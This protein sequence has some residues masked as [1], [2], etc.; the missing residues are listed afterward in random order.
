MKYEPYAAKDENT[1]ELM[2]LQVIFLSFFLALLANL[3]EQETWIIYVILSTNAATFMWFIYDSI[4]IPSIRYMKGGSGN[5]NLVSVFTGGPAK[6]PSYNP[7]QDEETINIGLST[8]VPRDD[9]VEDPH[10]PTLPGEDAE[11]HNEDPE[12]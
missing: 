2:S 8:L 3:L 5:Q 12:L 10:A 7:K 1:M 4:L 6:T 9:L 11:S